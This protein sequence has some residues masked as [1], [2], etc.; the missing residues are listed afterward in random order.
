MD[1]QAQARGWDG[2][3]KWVDCGKGSDDG[4]EIGEEMGGGIRLEGM[5][6][7]IDCALPREQRRS[8]NGFGAADLMSCPGEAE[9]GGARVAGMSPG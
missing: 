9:S 6:T 7:Q 2:W 5:K 4:E 8:A 3:C 1:R